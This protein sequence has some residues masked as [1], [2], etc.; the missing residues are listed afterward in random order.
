MNELLF[1]ASLVALVIFTRKFLK[2]ILEDIG[3]G[4]P[5]TAGG[6]GA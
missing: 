2:A 3:N 6:A 5:P 1:I 4:G